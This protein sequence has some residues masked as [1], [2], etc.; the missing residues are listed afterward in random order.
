MVITETQR[1]L[2]EQ[3]LVMQE[4]FFENDNRHAQLLI[5]DLPAEHKLRAHIEVSVYNE[6]PTSPNPDMIST[7]QVIRYLL[8]VLNGRVHGL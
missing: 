3:L 4:N 6:T 5:D 7:L 8:A 1:V 2:L